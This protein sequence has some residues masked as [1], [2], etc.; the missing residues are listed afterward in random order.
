M[1][2]Q[3][4]NKSLINR[5]LKRSISCLVQLNETADSLPRLVVIRYYLDH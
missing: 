2:S 4:A 1:R 3:P 5:R